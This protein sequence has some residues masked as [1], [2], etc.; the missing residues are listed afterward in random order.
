MGGDA[1]HITSEKW[2]MWAVGIRK[3]PDSMI[4]RSVRLSAPSPNHKFDQTIR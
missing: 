3:P 2:R 1:Y 4:S